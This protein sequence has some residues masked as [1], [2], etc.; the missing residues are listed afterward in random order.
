[1]FLVGGL[2][3]ARPG[4][5]PQRRL[6]P[7]VAGTLTAGAVAY[8]LLSPWLA[9]RALD[10]ASSASTP[11]VAA[12][13]AKQA[14]ALNPLSIDPLRTWAMAEFER[15]RLLDAY[16]LYLDSVELQPENPTALCDAGQFELVVLNE[17]FPAYV[18]L[19]DWYTVDRRGSR[20]CLGLLD[21]ARDRVNAGG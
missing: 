10:R 5:R 4:G 3:L 6:L 18:H 8:S 12:R 7:A 9:E 11:A 13:E 16:R 20:I 21:E 17:P 14:H 15:G 2:L 1:V 19:N